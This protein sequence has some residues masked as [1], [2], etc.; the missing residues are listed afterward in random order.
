VKEYA[1]YPGCSV[2]GTAR[3]YEESLLMTFSAMELNLVELE[4]WNCCGATLCLAVDEL[5]SDAMSSRNLAI[6]EKMGLDL[7]APC[8]A[9]YLVLIKTQD[10]IRRYPDIKAKMN[11]ALEAVGMEYHGKLRVRHPLDILMNDVGLKEI[12]ARVTKPL[13]GFRVAPYY[14]CQL[15]R[16]YQVF[17]HSFYPS[18]MDKLFEAL[19]AEVINYPL[20]TRCC[21]G[22]IIG[23]MEDVGLRLNQILLQEARKRGANCL[24]TVCPLCQFNLEC[25]QAKINKRYGS[26][27]S[28]PVLYFTQL[29]GLAMGLPEDQLGFNRA[30][31][32]VDSL[33]MVS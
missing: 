6:A 26:D 1:Y 10:H 28:L 3:H 22:S 25:Y 31:V 15:T 21:G 16:P 13:E 17:D 23:S 29:L 11:R 4:D 12:T 24:A 32:P 33:L 9:C 30:V 7:V 5:M 18:S 19:G 8:S 14:G 27:F 2:K 20:K